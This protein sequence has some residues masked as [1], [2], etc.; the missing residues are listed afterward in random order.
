[1]TPASSGST[2]ACSLSASSD[3]DKTLKTA[4]DCDILTLARDA[5]LYAFQAQHKAIKAIDPM[6]ALYRPLG[7]KDVRGA[8]TAAFTAKTGR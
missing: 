6:D 8:L 2:P 4:L 7:S 5:K 1:M 3:A